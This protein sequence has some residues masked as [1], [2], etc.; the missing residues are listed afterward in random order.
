M[1]N[2]WYLTGDLGFLDRDGYLTLV[3]RAKDMIV[4]GG[5]NI[6][7]VEVERAL[8]CHPAVVTTA[9]IGTCLCSAYSRGQRDRRRL[10]TPLPRIVGGIQGTK[11]GL[12]RGRATDDCERQ[13]SESYAAQTIFGS[14]GTRNRLNKSRLVLFQSSSGA[15]GTVMEVL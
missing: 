4:S 8:L 10:E 5:E 7:S 13:G 9:V 3:D 2:G 6:Y 11:G 15:A 12:V 1:R 14:R